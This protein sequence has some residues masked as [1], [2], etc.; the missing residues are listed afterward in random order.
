MHDAVNRLTAA[1]ADRYAIESQ[2]GAGGMATVYLATDLKH[3]RKVALKVLR[4]ELAAV[5][6]ADR[7]LQEIKTTANLQH[8]HILP[9]FDSGEADG[10]VYYVM[11][12]VEGESLREKLDRETQLDV[13]EAVKIATEVAD[14]LEYAHQQG[15]IHRDVKPENVLLHGGRPMVADFGIALALSHAGGERLTETGLSLGTPHYMSP[16]QA[17]A[18]RNL[19]NRSDVYSLGAM[20]YEMLTGSPPHTGSSAQAVIA[21]IVTEEVEAVTRTRKSVP[22]NV[23]GAVAKALEKLPADRFDSARDFARALADQSFVWPAVTTNPPA[24]Q[25]PRMA[26]VLAVTSVL[27]AALALWGWLR[28]SPEPAMPPPSRLAILAPDLGGTA[29]ALQRRIALTPDGS[30]VI[31]TAVTA[32]GG[33]RTMW[34]PLDATEPTELP[35]VIDFLAEYFISPDGSEI[36]GSVLSSRQLFRYSIAGGSSKPLPAG[37]GVP[38]FAAWSRDGSIWISDMDLEGGI[39]RLKVDGTVTRPFGVATRYLQLM[40]VLPDD[41]TALVIRT[42]QGSANG[43]AELLDLSTG[44]A[45]P[46]LDLPLVTIYYTVGHLVYCLPDGT[47]EAVPFD[48]DRGHVEG[49]AVQI[50]RGVSLTGAARCQL[51]VAEN[52]TVAYIPEE[53]RSLVFVDRSGNRRLA[54]D[55]RRNFHD[56]GFSPDGRRIAMDFNTPDGRDVWVL[57]PG[58]VLT[59]TT[60]DRDGHDPTWFPDGRSIAYTSLR[61]GDFGIYRARLGGGE[62]PESLIV[63]PDLAFTGLWL[64]ASDTLLTVTPPTGADFMDIVLVANGGRGPIEPLVSTRFYES[65]PAVSHDGRWLAYV[66]TQTGRTEVYVRAV[67]GDGNVVRVSV[68]GGGEPLFGPDGRELFYRSASQLFVAELVHEPE[69]AVTSRRALFDVSDIATGFPHTNYDL[70]PD[71]RTFVMVQSNPSSRIMVIQNLPALVRRLR[72]GED[73][74]LN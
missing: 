31:Y 45:T 26:A 2:L 63:A 43:P 3:D 39:A 23:A 27:A 58:G 10:F 74:V 14:A 33:D 30:S 19:T 71:G 8:P 48:P 62:P 18:A 38:M 32:E 53:P 5:L 20:L 11:P 50:A 9:L 52:G 6:G 28:P 40:Q 46:L 4:P 57:E 54:T 25:T 15:V 49:G 55:E 70:S 56:P 17:T 73:R 41:R 7:F 16:E 36:I 34:M 44:T 12:Y 42:P 61:D 13:A 72:G 60:F 35:G 59:R 67:A 51:A 1:L 29:T 69:L 47:L 66:S 37:I 22:P 24:R 65:H 68:D 64:G 21:K